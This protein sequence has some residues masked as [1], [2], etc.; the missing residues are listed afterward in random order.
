[1][2]IPPDRE[3][4]GLAIVC[5]GMAKKLSALGRVADVASARFF[6]SSSWP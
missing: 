1:L 5:F 4:G 6:D 3:E 2:S